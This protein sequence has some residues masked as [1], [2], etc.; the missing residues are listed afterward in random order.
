[1][2]GGRERMSKGAGRAERAHL[3][4]DVPGLACPRFCH[5]FCPALVGES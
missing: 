4:Q 5:A 1:M 3:H 2:F